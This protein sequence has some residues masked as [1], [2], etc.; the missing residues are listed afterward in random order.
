MYLIDALHK[1]EGDYQKGLG[2]IGGYWGLCWTDGEAF[3]LQAHNNTLALAEVEGTYY[4]SSDWKH[5]RA[6]L[7]NV[8]YHPFTEGETMK[9]TIGSDG[10]VVLE[11]LAEL[12]NDAGWYT[13]DARTQGSYCGTS[14]ASRNVYR[15]GT[16]S[17]T[18]FG[19]ERGDAFEVW[20]PDSEYAAIMGLKEKDA[21][22]DVPDYDDRWR[23]AYAEYLSEMHAK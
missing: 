20:D 16:T 1:A 10:A 12:K 17:A 8:N 2:D 9:L 13:W 15:G 14:Y 7:G 23:E 22:N 3:Y 18:E 4:F 5:L 19:G 11:N 21:W 6:A